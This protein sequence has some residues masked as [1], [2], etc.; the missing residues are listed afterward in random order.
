MRN[1]DPVILAVGLI[2][3]LVWAIGAYIATRYKNWY[4]FLGCVFLIPT[5]TIASFQ[6]ADYTVPH[7]WTTLVPILATPGVIFIV[8][9]MYL[10]MRRMFY[11]LSELRSA[12]DV[13]KRNTP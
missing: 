1:P 10:S 6:A 9:G 3:P 11:V 7:L 8:G 13:V 5:S 12:E 2:R 4:A